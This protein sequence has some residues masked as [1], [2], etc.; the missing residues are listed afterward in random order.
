MAAL[1]LIYICTRTVERESLHGIPN[2]YTYQSFLE[3]DSEKTNPAGYIIRQ[4]LGSNL[5]DRIRWRILY[6]TLSEITEL[7]PILIAHGLS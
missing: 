1:H 7:A 3:T 5:Y 6:V 4:W 2:V